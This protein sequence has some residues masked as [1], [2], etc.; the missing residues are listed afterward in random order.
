MEFNISES[1]SQARAAF[2]KLLE[3]KET[4]LRAGML[5]QAYSA[6]DKG[7]HIGGAF[8]ALIPLTA[9]YYGG[10]IDT[11]V[12]NPTDTGNDI[13]I[14]SKGHAVA[15]LAQI[16]ADMGYFDESVLYG[17]RSLNSILNGHPGPLLPGVHVSTG[18]LGEGICVAEGFAIAGNEERNST[19]LR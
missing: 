16:Y 3:V 1:C 5:E 12:E 4:S 6:A 15:A 11:D 14:L 10:Y 13:F 18:P 2:I 7:M 8:S 17:S 9:L 19:S